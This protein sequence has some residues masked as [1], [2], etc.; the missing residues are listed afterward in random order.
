MLYICIIYIVSQKHL[1]NIELKAMQYNIS[2][3]YA[4]YDNL[5]V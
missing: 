4:I 2:R 1:R 3:N 5:H